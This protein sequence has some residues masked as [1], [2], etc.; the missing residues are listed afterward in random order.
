MG[1]CTVESLINLLICLQLHCVQTDT[2]AG[3]LCFL[4]GRHRWRGWSAAQS[5]LALLHRL[6]TVQEGSVGACHR[7]PVPDYGT[8]EMGWGPQGNLHPVW[9]DVAAPKNQTGL[10]RI[11]ICIKLKIT[12]HN[13][14]CIIS[15]CSLRMRS[16]PLLAACLSWAWPSWLEV[17]PCTTSRL[18]TQTPSPLCCP[19]CKQTHSLTKAQFIFLQWCL[20]ETD[21]SHL[22]LY[23]PLI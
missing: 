7:L 8:W 20:L 6:P 17:L 2:P 19:T 15:L 3:G 12:P 22:L 23:N 11:P 9:Q 18:G 16:P 10:K 13:N 4:H 21:Y 1:H 14:K 5:P